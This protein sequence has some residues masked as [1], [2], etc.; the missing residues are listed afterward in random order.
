MY[1]GNVPGQFNGNR[2]PPN[3]DYNAVYR[4]PGSGQN[5]IRGP[6]M[7]SHNVQGFQGQ[8]Y[9]GS[10]SQMQYRGPQPSGASFQND[11]YTYSQN[12]VIGETH[13]MSGVNQ[14]FLSPGEMYPGTQVRPTASYTSGARAEF[15][16]L[17]QDNSMSMQQYQQA[18]QVPSNWNKQSS[19]TN[20]MM[21]GQRHPN[22]KCVFQFFII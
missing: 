17:V 14:S 16:G 11:P 12:K 2:L 7:Q 4:M 18:K 15:T 8:G 3:K 1:R 19:D 21:Y 20:M 13:A 6:S 10:T 9:T 5:Q 22:G